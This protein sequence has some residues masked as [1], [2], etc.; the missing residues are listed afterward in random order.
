[1]KPIER[2]EILPLGEYERI[3]E[4]FRGRIIEAKK[5]RRIRVSDQM[6][7]I[8][9]NRD[10][11]LLQIQEMLRTERI[12]NEKGI[13]HELETYNELVPGDDELS[14]TLFIEVPERER[15]DEMLVRW[16]AIEEH[17]AIEIQ[18][19]RCRATFEEGRRDRGRAAAVQYLK[20]PLTPKAKEAVKSRKG[21]AFIV[22][23]HPHLSARVELSAAT[24]AS[25]ADDLG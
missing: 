8:F 15:R 3:R 18:G 16:C 12:T 1:M 23:D 11:M 19:E 5:A 9:E 2:S 14:A 7:L 21:P 25:L 22:L 13:A 4:H 6:S 24:L 20:F 17:V 10:T